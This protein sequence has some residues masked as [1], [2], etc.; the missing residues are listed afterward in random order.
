MDLNGE[1]QP[2]KGMD[3]F[4]APFSAAV[5]ALPFK[6]Y[7]ST[8]IGGGVA[9]FSRTDSTIQV[10]FNSAHNITTNTGVNISGLTFSGSVD[11]NGNFIATVVDRQAAMVLKN[12]ACLLYI[13]AQ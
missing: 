12:A 1:W 4:S 11:P 9:S 2:R 7:D 5:L 13:L 6:L 3:I 10:N 8:N